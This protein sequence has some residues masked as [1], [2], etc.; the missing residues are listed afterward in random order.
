[1]QAL[2][3]SL[4][5]NDMK[6]II[7]SILTYAITS[8][9]LAQIPAVG[10]QLKV[11][12]ENVKCINKS[13]DGFVEWDGHGSEVSVTYSYRI[14]KPSNPSA[15]R[16]GADG[17]VI[18]GSSVNGMTRAGTQTPDLG[19]IANGDVVNIFKP[20]MDV[21]VDAEDI[22]LIAPNVWE[23][24]GPEKNTINAFNAQLERDLDWATNQPFPFANA[25]VGYSDVFTPIASRV[26]KIYDKY[27]YGP[28]LKY[29]PVFSPILCGGNTQGNRVMGILSGGSGA[30]CQVAFP[31]TLVALDT[32][33][34][35]GLYVNNRNSTITGTSHAEKE[36]KTTRVD[37]VTVTFTESTYAI[38]TSNGSYSVFLRIEFIPD[39]NPPATTTGSTSTPV[40]KINKD[41]PVRGNIN[42]SNTTLAVAGR[43]TGTQTN[44]YGMYPQNIAFELTTNNEFLIKDI[45]G[46]VAAKGTYSFSNNAISGSYKQFSSSET[47]SF[48][49]NFDPA[50]QK[51][52]CT[53]GSGNATTGQGKW[54]VTKN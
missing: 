32:R 9:C 27:R 47:F 6:K 49:G 42:T 50:M 31:P 43:W 10:G 8:G 53:L 51:I 1:M 12:I 44:D 36:S 30:S 35:Y 52:T 28:A 16:K 21:H 34:L 26:I 17:T 4:N 5:I 41:F 45:N 54:I 46:V 39:S 29:Q 40:K 18:Y 2:F 11:S 7:F 37:G 15:A 24:D 13:W 3:R 48:A 22:I 19:G 33:A 23:W 25:P 14:Y 38:T 20:I